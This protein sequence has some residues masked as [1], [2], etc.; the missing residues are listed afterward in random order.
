MKELVIRMSD[1]QYDKT[2]Q[3]FYIPQEIANIIKNGTPLDDI[4]Q[5]IDNQYKWL[6]Q[7]NHTLYDIDIAF[8]AI[9]QF[10]DKHTGKGASE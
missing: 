5:E 10:I 6:M 2:I 8:G 7:T 3:G 1:Y 4:Q 9:K